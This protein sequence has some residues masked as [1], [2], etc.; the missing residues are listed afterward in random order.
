MD[1][2]NNFIP[3]Q[4]QKEDIR[5]CLLPKKEKAPFEKEWQKEG[6]KYND[7]RLIN[8]LKQNNNYGVLGGFGNILAIDFDSQEI[9][10]KFAPL[11]PETFTI[12]TGSGKLHKYFTCDDCKSFKILDINK[13]TLIDFQGTGKQ[14]VAPGSTHPNGHHYCVIDNSEI[15]HISKKSLQNL[16]KEYINN[17][18][19]VKK[20]TGQDET[21][22]QIKDKVKLR[23]L[24]T[25]YG[26]DTSRHPTECKLGHG[27]KQ[28]KNFTYS[29]NLWFC[30]SCEEGGDIFNFVMT[31]DKC[32]F[33]TAKEKLM[34]KYN[35]EKKV[36]E[37]KSA[38]EITNRLQALDLLESKN[39]VE[40]VLADSKNPYNISKKLTREIYFNS[41]E[42]KFV[43]TSNVEKKGKVINK[44]YEFKKKIPLI[45]IGEK[46]EKDGDIIKN[47]FMI[48]DYM[49]RY[50][51]KK[52]E[53]YKDYYLY[54][55]VCDEN[56]YIL[57]SE[58][59]L[60]TEEYIITGMIVHIDNL[61]QITKE[62]RLNQKVPLLF[63]NK[64]ENNKIEFNSHQELIQKAKELNLDENKFFNYLFT[65]KNQSYRQPQWYERFIAAFLFSTE[66]DDYRSYLI[67]MGQPETGKTR[68]ML[69]VYDKFEEPQAH[70]SGSNSTIRGLI[71][72]FNSFP[73]KMGALIRSVRFHAIDEF[74]RILNT[75]GEDADANR[76]MLLGKLNSLYDGRKELFESGNGNAEG[77]MKCKVMCVSNP[78]YGCSDIVS[79]YNWLD[80]AFLSRNIIYF[81]NK[82]HIKMVKGGTL[83]EKS[84]ACMQNA[85]FK[86]VYDYFMTF[87]SD[88]K[89]HIV[90][91]IFD[92]IG[93]GLKSEYESNEAQWLHYT[94]RQYHHLNCL[95]DGYVKFRCFIE[96]DDSF[97]AKKEDYLVI[98][99][100]WFNI[101]NSWLNGLKFDRLSEVELDVLLD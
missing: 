83:L 98:E 95:M 39:K 89:E 75:G 86:A 11:L 30:F 15:A 8:W 32:D 79:M 35:I 71:P 38:D 16:F 21:T 78:A 55:F 40:I 2:I 47:V 1:D 88:Y 24:M 74:L 69:A 46:R 41:N 48:D 44:Y 100:I 33:A 3:K 81:Q 14:V 12:M 61:N 93:N 62:C 58:E 17:T 68:H 43:I 26:Y 9:Q 28:K 50:W 90:K 51:I 56:Q 59:K 54:D 25:E 63:I 92:K 36:V 20:T 13:N 10:D 60:E 65:I 99:G 64:A 66:F 67:T 53:F 42:L 80:P 6:Y 101:V 23:D 85:D 73:V 7:L 22:K 57:M 87:R 5:F 27:S 84:Q 97:K 29:D 31:H 91:Y 19:I 76:K 49:D 34:K 72:S 77:E 96:K 94:S 70:T 52:E 82:E 45:R 18:A 4:L 37:C